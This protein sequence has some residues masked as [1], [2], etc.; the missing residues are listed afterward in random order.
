MSEKFNELK[1]TLKTEAAKYKKWY[2]P[3]KEQ[4]AHYRKLKKQGY[5][6]NR[7]YRRG[8]FHEAF[9]NRLV[10]MAQDYG[11]T[12]E[13]EY[14]VD[15]HRYSKTDG[16]ID[17]LWRTKLDNPLVAIEVDTK[18]NHSAVEKLANCSA[19]YCI[20]ITIGTNFDL[21]DFD[22][23]GELALDRVILESGKVIHFI[24]V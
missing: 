17:V 1:R 9:Q 13:K 7:N 15:K 24:V 22:Y 3:T 6:V 4:I 18:N 19:K 8:N 20:W 16:Y 5:E 23:L 12:G 21:N 2:V 14:R 11:L 10:E